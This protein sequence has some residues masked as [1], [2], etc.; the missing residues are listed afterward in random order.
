VPPTPNPEQG[1]LFAPLSA[2][3]ILLRCQRAERRLCRLL[4]TLSAQDRL[5][6]IGELA[7]TDTLIE[8]LERC[9][10]LAAQFTR[11]SPPIPSRALVPRFTST[12]SWRRGGRAI[13]TSP[14]TSS[15]APAAGGSTPTR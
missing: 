9:A 13:R 14:I 4:P 3:M 2:P 12:A 11:T 8:K 15:T 5:L 7:L 6:V 1:D 10:Q